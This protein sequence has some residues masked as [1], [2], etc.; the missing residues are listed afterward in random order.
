MP[1]CTVKSI[2]QTSGGASQVSFRKSV[3]LSK[4]LGSRQVEEDPNYQALYNGVPA[5]L[6]WIALGVKCITGTTV[7]GVV[8]DGY[9]SLD[10]EF[11]DRKSITAFDIVPTAMELAVEREKFKVVRAAKIEA[12]MKQMEKFWEERKQLYKEVL[13]ETRE[14]NGLSPDGT[15]IVD[16]DR[17][18]LSLRIAATEQLKHGESFTSA[19]TLELAELAE[20]RDRIRTSNEFATGQLT[21]SKLSRDSPLLAKLKAQA[22]Q[23]EKKGPAVPDP[24]KH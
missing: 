24:V 14:A 19:M 7:A 2:G 15:K 6:F 3:P 23:F 5:D 18:L 21:T 17:Q 22:A 1:Y 4:I 11:Y 13:I 8:Y 20:A 12:E 16:E 10:V 9:I